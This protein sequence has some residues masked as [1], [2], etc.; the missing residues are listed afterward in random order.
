M[1]HYLPDM[2]SAAKPPVTH[3]CGVSGVLQVPWAVQR[4]GGREAGDRV[5]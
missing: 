2:I 5:E 4:G 3:A 1:D